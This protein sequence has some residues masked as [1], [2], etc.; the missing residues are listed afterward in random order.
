MQV[1]NLL[2]FYISKHSYLP[3]I[4]QV[5]ISNVLLVIHRVGMI[6]ET[7]SVCAVIYLNLKSFAV[8]VYIPYFF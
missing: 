1:V 3:S 2:S 6:M 4:R 8:K 7:Q 5:V